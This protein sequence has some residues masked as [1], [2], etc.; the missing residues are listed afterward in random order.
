MHCNAAGVVLV[1]INRAPLLVLTRMVNPLLVLRKGVRLEVAPVI[2]TCSPGSTRPGE[3]ITQAD[4]HEQLGV[5]L[6]V[7]LSAWSRSISIY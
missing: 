4:D 2:S 1:T 6:P 7:Q 3:P 5:P